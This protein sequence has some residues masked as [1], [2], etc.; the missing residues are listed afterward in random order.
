[1]YNSCWL[2]LIINGV[3]LV[4]GWL[5]GWA[6]ETETTETLAWMAVYIVSSYSLG[7][8]DLKQSWSRAGDAMRFE[9]H[10]RA[11][12]KNMRTNQSVD[13][14]LDTGHIKRRKEMLR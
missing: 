4:C 10:L 12:S 14:K 8:P 9:V 3:V 2:A 6:D 5:A 13:R 7:V 11:K 1:M